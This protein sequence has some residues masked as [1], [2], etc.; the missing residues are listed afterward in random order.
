LTGTYVPELANRSFASFVSVSQLGMTCS[1]AEPNLARE[2]C[3]LGISSLQR[4]KASIIP[5]LI[6]KQGD[7]TPSGAH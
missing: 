2:T 7:P 1:S 4:F 6:A 3:T 5:L